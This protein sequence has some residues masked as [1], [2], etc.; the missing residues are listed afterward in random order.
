M[1]RDSDKSLVMEQPRITNFDFKADEIRS[2]PLYEQVKRYISESILL[3]VWE[4]NM[5]LPGENELARRFGVAV[6][7]VRHALSDLTAEGMLS[8]RRKTGTVVTGRTPNHSLRFYFQYFRLH[9]IDGKMLNSQV[10]ILSS[11]SGRANDAERGRLA[12]T[13]EGGGQVIRI[14]RL[15]KIDGQP[16][17]LDD[18]VLTHERIPDFPI[19]DP[20]DLIYLY[21]LETYGIRITAV[22]ESVTAKLASEKDMAILGVS[23]PTALLRIDEVAYDPAGQAVIWAVH[24]AL[25][26]KFHYVNEVR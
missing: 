19:D 24:R 23:D 25:T 9:S 6:G 22:R 13:A 10:E 21:L 1:S 2:V 14:N 18:M 5:V 7:T 3:G 16:A 4:A 11:T 15:R 20:P 8:R 17:M 26:D 12:L